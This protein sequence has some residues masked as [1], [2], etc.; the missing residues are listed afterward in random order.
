M[1]LKKLFTPPALLLGIGLGIG[2]SLSSCSD[3]DGVGDGPDNGNPDTISYSKNSE[4]GVMLQSILNYT[5]GIDSLPDNW[6][7]NSYIEDATVGVLKDQSTPLVRYMAVNDIED[8]VNQYNNLTMQAL[9]TTTTSDSW[10]MD[11]IGSISYQ[12]NNQKDLYAT[13]TFNVNHLRLSELRLVPAYVLGNNADNVPFADVYYHTGDV[14]AEYEQTDAT[15]NIDYGHPTYWTCIRSCNGSNKQKSHWVSFQMGPTN[16]EV[17]DNGKARVTVP[18]DLSSS[19]RYEDLQNAYKFFHLICDKTAQN[20]YGNKD[21]IYKKGLGSL[22]LEY[23]PT[24]D[25]QNIISVWEENGMLDK[26]KPSA[27]STARF[28][29]LFS[30]KMI[31]LFHYSYSKSGNTYSL[32]KATFLGIAQ[33]KAFQCKNTKA[34]FTAEAGHN[35]DIQS[36]V[37]NA[38][39]TYGD[40][41]NR[42]YVKNGFPSNALVV[43]V[44]TGSELCGGKATQNEDMKNSFSTHNKAIVDYCICR[45]GKGDASYSRDFVIGG[46]YADPEDNSKWICL[47]SPEGASQHPKTQYMFISFDNLTANDDKTRVTSEDLPTAEQAIK[48]CRAFFNFSSGTG[49]FNG[50]DDKAILEN[51]KRFINIS[52]KDDMYK[53]LMYHE[54]D[55]TDT[56]ADALFTMSCAYKG[57][58][59]TSPDEQP[60]MRFVRA[61]LVAEDKGVGRSYIRTKY[62]NDFQTYMYLSDIKDQN[63]VDLYRGID[64]LSREQGGFGYPMSSGLYKSR[65][66]AAPDDT[67]VTSY[68][69]YNGTYPSFDPKSMYNEPM[70]IFRYKE[71]KYN[72]KDQIKLKLISAWNSTDPGDEDAVNEYGRFADR[73]I[74]FYLDGVSIENQLYLNGDHFVFPSI[75]E[76]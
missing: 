8:A 1:N 29:D 76:K 21:Y 19:E 6:A 42:Y 66:K 15:G 23:Y 68:F 48:A 47:L 13:I 2:V 62:P 67:D 34:K 74:L 59:N 57:D 35:F 39:D 30:E 25:V 33:T 12:V 64:C 38:C 63:K 27:M 22:G 46:V 40:I 51:V 5:S 20:L 72:Q 37:Y 4:T 55:N 11:S 61:A 73:F 50:V 58:A 17:I 52:L 24:E 26:I 75:E 54:P 41:N 32:Y 36:Y 3:K 69:L 65:T 31:D 43:R 28:K 71:Y 53:W 16:L 7:S 45:T 70:H 60:V 18:K 9:D 14:I 44:K 56:R 49:E 10:S